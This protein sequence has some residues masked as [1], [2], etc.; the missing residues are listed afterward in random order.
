M[1]EEVFLHKVQ[2]VLDNVTVTGYTGMNKPVTIT[3]R[4]CEYSWQNVA[5]TIMYR[6]KHNKMIQC[7]NCERIH[8]TGLDQPATLPNGFSFVDQYRGANVPVRLKHDCCGL[9]FWMQPSRCH[10]P[11]CSRSLSFGEVQSR[12]KQYA[13]DW[14]LIKYVPEQ[15]LSIIQHSC[16]KQKQIRLNR[17]LRKKTKIR[18]NCKKEKQQVLAQK[19]YELRK[20]KIESKSDQHYDLTLEDKHIKYTCK[21]CGMISFDKVPSCG[22]KRRVLN[23][24][25]FYQ[26][27]RTEL[28]DYELL[29]DFCGFGV[30]HK[31]KHKKCGTEFECTPSVLFSVNKLSKTLCPMC[32][33]TK[34]VRK[35]NEQV[36]Q[37]LDIRY[38][39]GAFTL[40]G[41]YESCDQPI[42]VKHSCGH[43]YKIKADSL[44]QNS[45]KKKTNSC[46]ACVNASVSAGVTTITRYLEHNNFNFAREWRISDCRDK[47]ALPFDFAVWISGELRLVEFD[48]Q[49]HYEPI[50]YFGGVQ[51]F[52][53]QQKHDRIKNEYCQA[54]GIPLLRIKYDE[55]NIG[56]ALDKFFD[57][58][59][60]IEN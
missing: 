50:D 36:Q 33:G 3:C 17:A 15:G 58:N 57:S 51:G 32:H 25:R 22:C 37:E 35:T 45:A 27:Y 47:V 28:K 13:P 34:G 60:I 30:K 31:W 54:H 55:T 10:C 5:R 44:L 56:E 9:V 2:N 39:A 46:P 53:N 49:Q 43:V 12:L 23:E 38:G 18:C 24:V 6:S 29:S 41:D 26:R 7:V 19:K 4:T 14:T 1:R 20:E 59:N 48:G 11:S 40:L 8:K 52:L 16:G 42:L 21:Y